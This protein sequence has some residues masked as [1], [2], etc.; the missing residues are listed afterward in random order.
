MY[1]WHSE[2]KACTYFLG[3]TIIPE[4]PAIGS[5]NTAA[6]SSGGRYK[7]NAFSISFRHSKVHDDSFF[8]YG[9]LI[10]IG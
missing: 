8:S 1:F 2:N 5:K 7:L 10:Q 9:H 6:T 3:G 4:S